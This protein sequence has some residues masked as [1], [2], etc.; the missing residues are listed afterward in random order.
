MDEK[1]L[2]YQKFTTSLY[3]SITAGHAEARLSAS[4]LHHAQKKMFSMPYVNPGAALREDLLAR[5]SMEV[6]V[7]QDSYLPPST[8]LIRNSLIAQ[9]SKIRQNP[10]Q[11][12]RKQL[13]NCCMPPLSSCRQTDHGKCP[14]RAFELDWGRNALHPHRGISDGSPM[15]QVT[16]QITDAAVDHVLKAWLA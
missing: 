8:V 5:P 15:H 16:M 6:E 9:L 2:H 7:W 14:S 10:V 3:V 12:I 13:V 4:P 1:A 11:I